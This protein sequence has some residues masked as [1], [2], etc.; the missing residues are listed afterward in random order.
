[1]YESLEPK[2]HPKLV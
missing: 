2:K 1:M